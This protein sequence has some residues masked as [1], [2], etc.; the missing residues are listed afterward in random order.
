MSKM[1]SKS[2]LVS[3]PVQDIEEVDRLASQLNVSRNFLVRSAVMCFLMDY[4]LHSFDKLMRQEPNS[5][6]NDDFSD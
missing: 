3:L 1:K 5:F 6:K 4:T 2:F